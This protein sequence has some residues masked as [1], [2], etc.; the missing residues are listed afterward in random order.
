MSRPG[1]PGVSATLNWLAAA[2]LAWQPVLLDHDQPYFRVARTAP[3]VPQAAPVVDAVA[4]RGDV[5]LALDID[6]DRTRGHVDELLAVMA[7]VLVELTR[8][9][10]VLHRQ[11]GAL[12]PHQRPDRAAGRVD[13]R[14][15]GR[16]P[17]DDAH[18]LGVRR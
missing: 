7:D 11:H 9:A 15:P 5:Q 2:P 14:L 8:R 1:Q 4:G 6:L 10:N 18:R 3:A 16:D 12:A 13:R 17:A